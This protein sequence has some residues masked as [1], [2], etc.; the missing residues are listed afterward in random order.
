M[1]LPKTNVAKDLEF[2]TEKKK[3]TFNRQGPK[4]SNFVMILQA[5]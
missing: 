5:Q 1:N 3:M 4:N 2:Q